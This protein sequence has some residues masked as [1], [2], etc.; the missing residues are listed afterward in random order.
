[1]GAEVKLLVVV[2]CALTAGAA[3]AQV[4]RCVDPVTKK[5]AY[6]DGPCASG[7]KSQV[8]ARKSTPE[9][10][11]QQE[12]D[13]LRARLRFH[14]EVLQADLSRLDDRQQRTASGAGPVGMSGGGNGCSSARRNV[15]VQDSS[16]T[17]RGVPHGA[18]DA[19][20]AA[21]GTYTPRVAREFAEIDRE[22]EARRAYAPVK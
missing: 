2:F 13:A 12:L 15:E 16:V 18:L 14:R 11:A 19:M 21:C 8:I 17:R 1:M 22:R 9:E 4:T 20:D 5:V 3:S 6:T 7:E 10:Q